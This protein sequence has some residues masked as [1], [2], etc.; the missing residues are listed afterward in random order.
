MTVIYYLLTHDSAINH[1]ILNKSDIMHFHL[2]GGPIK[3]LLLYPDGR[4]EEHT[5]GQDIARGEVMQLMVPAATWKACFLLEG[6]YGLIS[7]SVAPGFEYED[8][9]L[10]DEK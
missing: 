5:L 9:K 8:M 3:Y 6:D 1:W 4:L 2:Q 10:G 7:E